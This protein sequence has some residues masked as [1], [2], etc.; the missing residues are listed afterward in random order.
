[1]DFKDIEILSNVIN[2]FKD[3]WIGIFLLVILKTINFLNKDNFH[4]SKKVEK[5]KIIIKNLCLFIL[6]TLVALLYLVTMFLLT[7]TE[8]PVEEVVEY[9]STENNIGEFVIILIMYALLF[10]IVLAPFYSK[11]SYITFFVEI[12]NN[13]I[14]KR[15]VLARKQ[16]NGRD[17]LILCDYQGFQTEKDVTDISE[18]KFEYKTI[19]SQIAIKD[20]ENLLL[21]LKEK[22]NTLKIFIFGLIVTLPTI[23]LIWNISDVK[24]SLDHIEKNTDLFMY[25]AIFTLPLILVVELYYIA[26]ITY[27]SLFKKNNTE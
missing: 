7:L 16:I 13:N 10:P 25:I 4:Q 15:E 2:N 21:T 9:L 27:K 19:K 26:Y 3:V 11:K 18:L 20:L 6:V 14:V 1:M 8:Y 22:S 5:L 12:I 24:K 17:K 23:Y